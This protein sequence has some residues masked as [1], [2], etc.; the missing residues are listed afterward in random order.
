[1]T[2]ALDFMD[3][4]DNRQMSNAAADMIWNNYRG[5][6][7]YL[8]QTEEKGQRTGGEGAGARLARDLRNV[9]ERH[10]GGD[11]EMEAFFARYGG[12]ETRW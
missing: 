6:K 7:F 11:K 2:T 12:K 4:W 5:A 10:G 9:V 1:M 8:T 3:L